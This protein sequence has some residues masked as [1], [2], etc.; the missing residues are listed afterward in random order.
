M[1]RTLTLSQREMKKVNNHTKS[2][3]LLQKTTII[4]SINLGKFKIKHINYGLD[5]E[6]SYSCAIPISLK[7]HIN[8]MKRFV[9]IFH[10][11]SDLKILQMSRNQSGKLWK[12][13]KIYKFKNLPSI[14]N[15]SVLSTKHLFI[16]LI[17]TCLP[18]QP[19]PMDQDAGRF[20]WIARQVFFG[21]QFPTVTHGHNCCFYEALTV[22]SIKLHLTI[23]RSKLSIPQKISFYQY[24][25]HT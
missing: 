18:I 17:I 12:L 15:F 14:H 13:W 1:D 11:W 20:N 16:P 23:W 6:K 22:A 2:N 24:I 7:G 9:G 5:P 21:F 8:H 25:Y 19:H 3:I 10:I 4:K